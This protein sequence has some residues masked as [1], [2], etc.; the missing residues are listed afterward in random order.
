MPLATLTVKK[1]V[2]LRDR[3]LQIPPGATFVTFTAVTVADQVKRDN[4]YYP[5][6]KQSVVE[7]LLHFD[8]D[9]NVKR[10][11]YKAGIDPAEWE[12]DGQSWHRPVF[13]DGHVTA[14]SVD[15]AT[16]E[17]VY[18]R[19]RP[20]K[21]LAEPRYFAAD[22]TELSATEAKRFLRPFKGSAKQADLGL[23]EKQQVCFR[24]YK[25]E[26]I[27]ELTHRAAMA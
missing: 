26:S 25:L 20:L 11:A 3:L 2:S 9:G 7:G 8:Y 1:V 23:T 12:D 21:A 19:V 17:K 5:I 6:A 15:K 4:P 14:L 24:L 18:L 22:G 10:A 27:V 13:V 16:G